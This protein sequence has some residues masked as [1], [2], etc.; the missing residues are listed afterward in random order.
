MSLWPARP[1]C[2]HLEGAEEEVEEELDVAQRALGVLIRDESEDHLVDAQ[3]RDQ[4]QRG[5]GQ[6]ARSGQP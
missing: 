5:L 2:T 4:R 3:Q 6:P 1:Y